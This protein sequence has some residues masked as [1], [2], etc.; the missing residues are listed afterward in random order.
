[1]SSQVLKFYLSTPLCAVQLEY[2]VLMCD[3]GIEINSWW[4]HLLICSHKE[5]TKLLF[6]KIGHY[7][8]KWT[9]LK[10]NPFENH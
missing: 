2:S 8:F 6:L 10:K 4:L 3:P 9:N 1:M 7:L 5:I